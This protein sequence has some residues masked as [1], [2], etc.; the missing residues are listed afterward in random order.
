MQIQFESFT[1]FLAMGGYGAYV[2]SGYAI[3]FFSLLIL[4]FY[5]WTGTKRI[6]MDINKQQQRQARIDK[7]KQ[8]ENTL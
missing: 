7:A 6:I 4:F 8:R 5:S 2:W 1:D 3:V